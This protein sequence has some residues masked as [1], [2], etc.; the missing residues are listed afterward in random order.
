VL[1][2]SLAGGS[3]VASAHPQ[4]DRDGVAGHVYVNNNT[5]GVNTI[6]GFNRNEDGSL[7][8]IPGS[9][10]AIGGAGIGSAT[11]SAGALQMSA[12]GKYLLAVDAGSN[13]ISVARI[14]HDGSLRPVSS[15]P[16][17]SNGQKPVSIGVSGDLVYVANAGAGG[18]NYTGFTLNGGGHLRPIAQSTFALPDNANPGHVLFSPDG[19]FLV[20]I[21]VGP[22]AGPSFIDTFTVGQDGR[23]TAAAGSPFNSQAVGPFGSVFNPAN[24][25][26]L[27][28]TNA[29]AGPG[30]GSVSVYNLTTGGVLNAIAGS[31]FADGQTAACWAAITRDGRELFVVN[32]GSSSI[33]SY[34]VGSDGVLTVTGTA[35]MTN[36]GPGGLGAFDDKLTPDGRY[37]YVVDA[38]G[39]I[40]GFSVSA[41][42]V[43]ELPSSP[44]S[45]TAGA[46]P[47]GLV[48]D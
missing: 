24:P 42:T 37:L 21:R 3:A 7:T 23:L 31:P 38:S 15:S 16:V 5:A 12:D 8:P 32:T 34:A 47:F 45:L 35:A 1:A 43:T 48:V 36:P 6:S 39:R 14:G 11:G 22:D 46:T 4:H 44:V 30:A 27:F 41:G 19:K 9:P 25:A 13:Q 20:G 18:S 28:V 33:S 17:A 2:L 40:S 10:F 26:Q 29:H